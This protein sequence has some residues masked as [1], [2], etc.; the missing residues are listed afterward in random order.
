MGLC[1]LRTFGVA[2]INY[3]L[4]WVFSYFN[5]NLFVTLWLT[6]MMQASLLCGKKKKQTETKHKLIFPSWLGVKLHH[7]LSA[8]NS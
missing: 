7:I 3:F 1:I 6:I 4:S 8:G 5:K 2:R